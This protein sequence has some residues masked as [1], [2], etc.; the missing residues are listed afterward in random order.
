MEVIKSLELIFYKGSC[1][2]STM[3][4]LRGNEIR[5]SVLRLEEYNNATATDYY[6]DF[7]LKK[8]T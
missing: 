5:S 7:C 2:D 6:L 3:N 4:F 8:E 1:F